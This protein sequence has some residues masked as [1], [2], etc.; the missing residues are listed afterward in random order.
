MKSKSK[1]LLA[2]VS[3]IF[4]AL[5]VL[6]AYAQ[7]PDIVTAEVDRNVLTT[8]DY[9]KLNVIIN[10]SLGGSLEP[11]LPP[12]DS[13]EVVGRSSSSSLSI[14]NGTQSS[15]KVFTY[16]LRPI[17]EGEQI[18]APISV[19]VSGQSFYTPPIK[20]TITQGTGRPPAQPPTQPG[21]P[22]L[23]SVPG[24]PSLPGLSGLLNSLGFDIPFDLGAPVEQLDPFAVPPALLEQ[25]YLVEAEVDK[26][27]PYLGE[28]V[29]YTF[30]YYRPAEA[31]GIH[32]YGQPGFTGFWVH[33]DSEEKQYGTQVGGRNYRMTEIK[34]VLFPTVIGEVDIDPATI[35]SEGDIFS[36]DF[37]L[38][39][40]PETID[41][42][43][44]PAGAPPSF[45]GA[46]G[47]FNIDA[48][49]DAQETKVNDA[50]NVSI[51]I[52]GEGNL[53]TFAD[54]VWQVGAEWRAFD[55]QSTTD[56][57]SHEG[58]LIGM[59]TINQVLVPTKSGIFTLPSIEFG[60]FDPLGGIYQTTRTQPI[61]IKVEPNGAADVPVT[62][63]V[64]DQ[65]GE[66]ALPAGGLRPIKPV[67]ESGSN[68]QSLTQMRGFWLLWLVPL[69]L[70]IG[71][72]GWH[73]WRQNLLNNPEARRSQK[74]AKK[75]YQALKRVDVDSS[76]YYHEVGRILTTYLSEKLNLSVIGITQ[77]ELSDLLIIHGINTA[78]VEQVQAC[79]A[80][81][82]MGQYAPTSQIKPGEFHAET[83]SLI[84]K[85]E[86]QFKVH[87]QS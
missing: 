71:Q 9:L 74:A 82:E 61:E 38:R 54:P 87:K 33:P 10:A 47:N 57:Q 44:L 43:P 79:I 7:T 39:T 17:R 59:R 36:R 30:R 56:I 8:D 80:I 26:S 15:K 67:P 65:P 23:P 12:L 81:S 3:A 11:L 31:V 14:I 20:V 21:N 6:P 62:A 24:F 28:Q 34:T 48:Q 37:T 58:S 2:L 29:T 76:E 86:V 1:T 68:E 84:A 46:V 50:V 13:F 52:S 22:S 18:I 77:I 45:S 5:I 19:S 32:S 55:S 66:A 75:A 83:R 35:T 64:D 16:T 69:F 41:V 85:L 4:M 51:T 49:V 70:L 63:A 78:L 42:Q 40:Q 53:D 73:L 60:Y 25:G 72:L 27:S